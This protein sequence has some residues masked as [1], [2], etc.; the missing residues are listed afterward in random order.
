MRLDGRV[1]YV[2]GSTRG[3]GRAV[4][5]T[6]AEAGASV[7]VNGHR[8]PEAPDRYAAELNERF[9]TGCIGISAD[10][11]DPEEQECAEREPRPRRQDDAGHRVAQE[12]SA[13]R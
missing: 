2:T 8:D 7:V 11:R 10:Q 4:A 13:D 9:G 6:L 12:L 3:I 1:A 5:A